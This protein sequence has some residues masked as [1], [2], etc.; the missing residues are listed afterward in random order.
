MLLTPLCCH[1]ALVPCDLEKK[2]KN[3]LDRRSFA[4]KH[5]WCLSQ[6]EMTD[7]LEPFTTSDATKL[8]K[9]ETVFAFFL[10]KTN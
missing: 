5:R 3:D 4:T 6:L 9:N 1:E 2:Q 10:V 8:Q 7:T